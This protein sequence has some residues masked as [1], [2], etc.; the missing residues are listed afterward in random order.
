MTPGCLNKCIKVSALPT[1][2]AG[3]LA[4]ATQTSDKSSINTDKA[5]GNNNNQT[6][7]FQTYKHAVTLSCISDEKPKKQSKMSSELAKGIQLF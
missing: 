7:G 6:A 1:L 2:A 3:I 5:A 4:Q